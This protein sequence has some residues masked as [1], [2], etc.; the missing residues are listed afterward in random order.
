MAPTEQALTQGQRRYARWLTAL[1][2]VWS[3]LAMCA[4]VGSLSFL[5][6]NPTYGGFLWS[7][8]SVLRLYRP[9]DTYIDPAVRDH[10]NS[11]TFFVAV[12]GRDI[13]PQ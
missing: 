3:L 7:Y 11:D 10:L 9:D 13:H 8:E 1:I 5:W 4:S 6:Q 12:N 2:G